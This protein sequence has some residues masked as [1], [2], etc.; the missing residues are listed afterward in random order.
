MSTHGTAHRPLKRLVALRLIE[1]ERDEAE[2]LKQRQAQQRCLD[3][4]AAS[5]ARELLASQALH[6]ALAAGDRS[7]SISAEMALTF[8]PLER[9]ALERNRIQSELLVE[10]ATAA[11][12]ASRMRRLQMEAILKEVEAAHRK[13]MLLREQ[14]A[15]DGWF[16]SA[17]SSAGRQSPADVDESFQR[18]CPVTARRNGTACAQRVAE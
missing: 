14:K 7:E 9:A 16:L 3:A 12:E 5:Q 8:G 17:R 18:E 13:E 1:E 15:L 6:A 11:W 2:L 10:A 4:L